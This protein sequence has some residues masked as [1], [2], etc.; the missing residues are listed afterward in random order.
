MEDSMSKPRSSSSS[1]SSKSSSG[2]VSGDGGLE[3]DDAH[4]VGIG[5]RGATGGGEAGIEGRGPNLPSNCEEGRRA[6]EVEE[7]GRAGLLD[8]GRGPSD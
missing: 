6:S 5:G 1:S 8:T 7:E 3:E 4:D 2:T